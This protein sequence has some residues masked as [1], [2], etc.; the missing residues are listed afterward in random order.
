LHLAVVLAVICV[1]DVH[2]A[3]APASGGS[4]SGMVRDPQG[5][6]LQGVRLTAR[7]WQFTR[8]VT[9]GPDGT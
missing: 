4:I 8:V 9:T 2:V 5:A 3:A 7:R 6:V 1:I